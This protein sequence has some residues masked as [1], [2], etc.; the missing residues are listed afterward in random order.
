MFTESWSYVTTCCKRP[1]VLFHAHVRKL[2]YL[3]V[4]PKSSFIY[5]YGEHE[6]NAT[7][8]PSDDEEKYDIPDGD[9]L[10]LEPI[11]PIRPR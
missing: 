9:V 10:N 6:N 5:Y 2:S 3:Q 11:I 8:K 7:Y 4:K 1:T